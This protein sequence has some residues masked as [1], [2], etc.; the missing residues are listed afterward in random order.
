MNSLDTIKHGIDKG[1]HVDVGLGFVGDDYFV[2]QHFLARGRFARALLAMR[3]YGFTFGLGVDED[4][5]IVL[6]DGR[7]DVVGY[8]GVL[9]LDL[10]DATTDRGLKAFNVK[11]ARLSYLDAG[12]RMDLKTRT[13]TVHK[14]KAAGRIDPRANDFAPSE[15]EPAELY[16]ADILGSGAIYSAIEKRAGQQ[17]RRRR[18]VGLRPTARRSQE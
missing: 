4:T 7:F 9:V 16:F 6:K 15:R 8:N 3:D 12:D 14:L 10:S 11:K 2:D 5:A 13:I 17:G 18:R 1:K